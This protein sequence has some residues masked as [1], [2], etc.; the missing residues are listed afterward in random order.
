MRSWRTASVC[1][2]S[3]SSGLPLGLIW[4]SIPDW[5]RSQGV[6]IR[7]VGMF[8]LVH[9][10]WIFK[11]VWAPL[12]DRYTPPW[13]GRRRG[14]MLITQ[15]A[16]CA[17]ML[18]LAGVGDN[19][20]VLWVVGA[21]ALAIAFASASQDIVIDAY[22]VDVL[23]KEEQ[24]VV[25]GARI[26]IYRVAMTAVAGGLA[27]YAA[28]TLGWKAVNVCLA[29]LFLPMMLISWKAP[30]P[31]TK[32]AAPRTLREAIWLPFLGCLARH[33]ALEI[34]AFVLL[35]KLADSLSQ[36]LLRPF[37]IDMGYN[38][39]DRGLWLSTVG[40]LITIAGTFLGGLACTAIGLGHSL[41]IFGFLQIFSNIGYILITYWPGSR[42]VM[43]AAMAFELVTTGLGMG[44][45]GV[46]LL[47]MTQ[48]RFS[49]TQYALFSSLFALPRM[50]AGP[51]T[52]FVVD[53]AGWKLFFVGTMVA[54][55]P[56]MVLLY[57][58]VPMGMRDP[59]FT[60]EPPRHRKPLTQIELWL[61]GLAGAAV[62]AVTCA[63]LMAALNA[64]KAMRLDPE[65]GFEMAREMA[66]LFL[67]SA[68]EDWLQLL[69][70]AVIAGASGLFAAAI[71]AARHG[72]GLESSA[73][74][75]W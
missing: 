59:V 11:L 71:S 62:G 44:A 1:L 67:P 41:W 18:F 51:V 58:F 66:G 75:G 6:D 2:L 25:V 45:F 4:Y 68:T 30:E 8:T 47:R 40:L 13:W 39:T 17:L 36:S 22:A 61:R 53:A 7:L 31:E 43:Y 48:K 37:L 12:M 27:I 26:A 28:E 49:A 64:L 57:R 9:A 10:P 69:A 70:L 72:E 20:D 14:W 73:E 63:P 38:A 32:T 21:L 3:F 19:P 15:V 54:G 23:R 29:L 34:L 60:V 56:G 65:R 24:G 42:P 52:G 35:Y 46:L 5:M 33:R 16:L 55:I 74:T 50:L